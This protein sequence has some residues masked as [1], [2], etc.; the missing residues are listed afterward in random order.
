MKGALNA[1]VGRAD[2][3]LGAGVER[4]IIAHHRRRLTARGRLRALEPPDD[5]LWTVGGPPPREGNSIEPLIDGD[6]ALARMQ[7]ALQAA[8]SSVIVAGWHV[9][10]AFKLRRDGPSLRE[11][12][13]ELAKRVEVRVL[14]WAGA[15]LP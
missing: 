12:L 7:D 3:Q 14:L 2:A 1:L 9:S 5:G 13:A 8:A 11:L 6:D 4:L 15:P 10:P